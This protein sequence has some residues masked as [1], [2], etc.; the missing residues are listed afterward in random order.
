[1]IVTEEEI[2]K[3][4]ILNQERMKENMKEGKNILRGKIVNNI[5]EGMIGIEK[6]GSKNMKSMRKEGRTMNRRT[7]NIRKIEILKR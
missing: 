1:M 3:R 7:K 2:I 6:I 4:I 5:Q